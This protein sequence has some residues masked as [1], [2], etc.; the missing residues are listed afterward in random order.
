MGAEISVKP[1]RSEY[2]ERGS[3]LLEFGLVAIVLFMLIF[4]IID[5][6]RAIS[7]YHFVANA[8]REAT[9]Y[10]MVR[11]ADCSLPTA[12]PA[13]NSDVTAYVKSLATGTGIDSNA[14]EV[15][16]SWPSSNGT[17]STNPKNPGCLV[18]VQVSYPF[19][20]VF[21]MMPSRTCTVNVG[22]TPAIGNIC[23]SSTS[24]MVISQ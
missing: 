17:C 9:R 18:V 22:N 5:F 2:R 14:V 20:F 15:D 24:Q 11:G 8:A 4:G 19:K 21:P 1:K 7:A 3:A 16:A 13:Q 12:C 23:M 6:A 10:A